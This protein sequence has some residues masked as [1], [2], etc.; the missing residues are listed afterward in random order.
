M[1]FGTKMMIAFTVMLA[2]AFGIGGSVLISAST[3]NYLNQL[4]EAAASSHRLI[5]FTLS[6][7]SEA[8]QTGEQSGEYEDFVNALSRLDAH[9]EHNWLALRL[10]HEDGRIIYTSREAGLFGNNPAEQILGERV[11]FYDIYLDNV[12]GE[13]FAMLTFRTTQGSYFL[14]LAG[15]FQFGAS[16]LF[17]ESV[18]DLSP[19]FSARQEQ[20]RIYRQLFV[21]LIALGAALSWL[22]SFWM[23][24]PLRRLSRITRTIAS[25]DLSCRAT[26]IGSDEIGILAVDF[27]NMTDKLENN[28]NEMKDTMKRQEEFMGSFAHE[29]K[30]PLTSIIGYADLLRG[31]SLP[32]ADKQDAANYIF[33]EGRR[34]EVL[35]LKLLDLIVLKKRDFTFLPISIAQIIGDAVRLVRPVLAKRNIEI[36]AN[37]DGSTCKIEP[38]LFMSLIL[39][40]IDNARKAIDEAGEIKITAKSEGGHCEI[41]IA[42]NGRGIPEDELYKIKDAF[43]RVDKSRARSQGG[44]GLGLRLCDEIASLH[45]GELTFESELN[46]GTTVTIKLKAETADA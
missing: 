11:V 27:N 13:Q 33:M 12:S 35:S 41:K 17:L 45:G 46:V 44:V 19:V 4:Q 39:N 7:V 43:Y 22:L 2:L 26:S 14:Q 8:T 1:K 28:I 16:A 3:G 40:I 37:C 38:D 25:G 36:S 21:V 18:Y 31:H 23:T 9:G 34:L 29:L 6:A 32:D 24:S 20:Q 10:S 42:D 30:T 5:L 15:Q